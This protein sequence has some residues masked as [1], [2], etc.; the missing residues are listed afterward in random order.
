ME[1]RRSKIIDLILE[2]PYKYIIVS[3]CGPE[4]YMWAELK[5]ELKSTRNSS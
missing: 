5:S 1:K 3:G 4:H 2:S